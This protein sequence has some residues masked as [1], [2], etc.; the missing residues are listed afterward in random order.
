LVK[1]PKRLNLLIEILRSSFRKPETVDYPFGEMI[2]QD[3]FRGKVVSSPDLCIGCGL[4]V[5]YCPGFALTLEKEDPRRFKLLYSPE[6]CAFC[7]QCEMICPKSAI[8]LI[9][10]FPPSVTDKN[11]LHEILVNKLDD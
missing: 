6:K 2:I 8:H 10:D 5:R 7:G 1:I 9:N 11:E 4:C 3:G